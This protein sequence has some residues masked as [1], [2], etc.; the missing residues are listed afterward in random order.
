MSTKKVKTYM[1]KGNSFSEYPTFIKYWE[2]A[3]PWGWEIRILTE[4]GLHT[5]HL[6]W[7]KYRRPRKLRGQK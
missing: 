6:K 4:G 1:K 5:L 2:E 7:K 3:K